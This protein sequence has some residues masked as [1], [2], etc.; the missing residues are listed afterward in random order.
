MCPPGLVSAQE[1]RR[2][3][4]RHRATALLWGIML[5]VVLASCSATA[6]TNV[7]VPS[8]TERPET[9]SSESTAP[10]VPTV[11]TATS[12]TTPGPNVVFTPVDLAVL[13]KSAQY[14]EPDNVTQLPW[15][16]DSG[17]VAREGLQASGFGGYGPCCLDVF[18]DGTVV[19]LDSMN[20]R[21][22]RYDGQDWSVLHQFDRDQ[23]LRPDGIAALDSGLT[24]VASFP[25]NDSLGHRTL[26]LIDANGNVVDEGPVPIFINSNWYGGENG[27]AS[28]DFLPP[29]WVKVT[30][31]GE[32][33]NYPTTEV[34][35]L[36]RAAKERWEAMEPPI[37]PD[38]PTTIL[39]DDAGTSLQVVLG[40]G[41]Y[42]GDPS[43]PIEVT[44]TAAGTPSA[45]RF[46]D[47][48]SATGGAQFEAYGTG[49]VG[50]WITD[51]GNLIVAATPERTSAFLT[52]RDQVAETGTYNT[53]RVTGATLYLLQTDQ[54][55]ARIETYSLS[56]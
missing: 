56:P 55:G 47:Y 38:L 19:I 13:L 43:P 45:W 20:L 4:E 35:D 28:M 49:V 37:P 50:L 16:S 10:P 8:M 30:E 52:V 44:V 14:R 7:D 54:H 17:E 29:R 42:T 3:A 24:M 48:E 18:P 51:R 2:P 46:I 32:V 33:K 39:R 6:D 25:L 23:P 1:G 53:F 12:T 9:S 31:S 15:G 22:Q 41:R 36:E 34:A 26:Q 11:T 27:W 40:E 21:V 5:V